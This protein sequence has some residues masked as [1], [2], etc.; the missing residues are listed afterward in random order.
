MKIPTVKVPPRLVE[1]RDGK[2]RLVQ[3]RHVCHSAMGV[4]HG[5]GHNAVCVCHCVWCVEE[6]GEPASS[7]AQLE[8]VLT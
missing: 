1:C 6:R 7:A 3:R 4:P 2:E 8:L 5:E